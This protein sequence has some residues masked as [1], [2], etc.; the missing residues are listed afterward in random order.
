MPPLCGSSGSNERLRQMLTN[1]AIKKAKIWGLEELK[2]LCRAV[3]ER[4][5][6]IL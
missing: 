6:N 4:I 5:V 3:E 2:M 1:V